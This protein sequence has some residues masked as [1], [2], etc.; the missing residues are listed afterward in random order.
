VR[1]TESQRRRFASKAKDLGRKLLAE[2]ATIV[3]PETLLAWHRQW[4][5][6]KYD[7]SAKRGPGR[8]HTLGEIEVFGDMDGGRESRLGYRPRVPSPTWGTKLPAVGSPR[9]WSGMASNCDGAEAKDTL[10][11]NLRNWNTHESR[12]WSFT[13]SG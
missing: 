6:H 8:P 1:F 11:R 7:Q 13:T 12:R 9:F 10:P 3:T 2:I 4:I 5:A